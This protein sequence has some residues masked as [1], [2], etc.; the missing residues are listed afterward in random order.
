M[1]KKYPQTKEEFDQT[2]YVDILEGK[3]L[4]F[5][6]EKAGKRM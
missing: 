5:D 2:F 3:E 1:G 6:L 4:K